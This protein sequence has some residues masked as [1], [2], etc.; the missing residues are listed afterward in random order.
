MFFYLIYFKTFKILNYHLQGVLN[1]QTVDEQKSDM[2]AYA[3]NYKKIL[4]LEWKFCCLIT[5]KIVI[6][7]LNL[8]IF[9]FK[10]FLNC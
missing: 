4:Q 5:L 10:A 6:I 1:C 7:T 9:V 8:N 3:Q 2:T